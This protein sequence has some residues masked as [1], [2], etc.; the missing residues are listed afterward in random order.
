M[1]K[2]FIAISVLLALFNSIIAGNIPVLLWSPSASMADLPQTIA[3]KTLGS[4][5]FFNRYLTKISHQSDNMVVFMQDK[6]DMQDFTRYADVYNP[7]SDGGSFRNLKHLLNE[8]YSAQLPSVTSTVESVNMLAKNKDRKVVT[9]SK[10]SDID[11]LDLNTGA[12]LLLVKLTPVIGKEN[13]GKTLAENDKFIGEVTHALAKR[14]IAYTAVYTGESSQTEVADELPSLRHLLSVD[15]DNG[16]FVNV[17]GCMYLYMLKAMISIKTGN[18][19]Y[20]TELKKPDDTG[21]MCANDSAILKLKFEN[22]SLTTELEMKIEL[23]KTGGWTV[24]NTSV[25]LSGQIPDKKFSDT[26]LIPKM[27]KVNAPVAFSYHCSS[28]SVQGYQNESDSKGD[29]VTL[30]FTEFQL[31]PFNIKKDQFSQAWDCV[32]FFT[33]GIWMGISVTIFIV[34]ILFFGMTMLANITTQDRFDD[35]KGKTITVNVSE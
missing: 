11:S 20:D 22:G 18:T 28:L 24:L 12:N 17:S 10:P 6:L 13:M 27:S 19:T 8:H 25:A 5:D 16:T 21:S 3:G 34:A 29:T 1:S 15:N 31:Q 35:P 33:A 14:G 26:I 32:P 2:S 9:V 30:T 23:L 7:H 4:D